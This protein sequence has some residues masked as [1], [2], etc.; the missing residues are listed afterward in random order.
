MGELNSNCKFWLE[1]ILIWG[2][3]KVHVSKQCKHVL[4]RSMLC[5]RNYL[6]AKQIRLEDIAQRYDIR[7]QGRIS[8]FGGFK[9]YFIKFIKKI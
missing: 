1:K 2:T 9:H 5:G 7:P 8:D 4:V 3:I 6:G